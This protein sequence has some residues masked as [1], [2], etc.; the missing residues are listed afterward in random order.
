[1]SAITAA[2]LAQAR[3]DLQ[4][5]LPDRATITRKTEASDG[6]GGQ[7]VTYPQVA[8]DVHCKLA[9][10]SQSDAV[11]V[12]GDQFDDETTHTIA[13]P[14]GQDVRAGDKIVI[15]AGTYEAL[16]VRTGG[17]WELGRHVLARHV[18]Q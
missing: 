5:M 1:M 4:G 2:E 10:A 15:A 16:H 14:H 13:F 3:A 18:T 7:D 12:V 17:A 11:Q 9:P 8:T 6:V